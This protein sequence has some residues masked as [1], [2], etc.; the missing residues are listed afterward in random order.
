[1]AAELIAATSAGC[2][3]A[4][5][6]I[7]AGGVVAL[8]TDTFYGLV[9]DPAQP[10]ALRRLARIKDRPSHMP[11]PLLIGKLS[12]LDDLVSSFPVQAQRLAQQWW[13]GALTLLLP[14]APGLPAGMTGGTGVVGLRIAKHPTVALTLV[15]VARP[16]TGT[17]ANR[18]GDPPPRTVT[19]VQAA[20]EGADDG[21]D[22][23]VDGG[24][25]QALAASTVVDCTH[26]PSVVVVRQGAI[27]E[28]YIQQ[29]A[30]AS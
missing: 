15:A 10:R 29:I 25:T 9:V 18:S 21:P 16:V 20:F 3:R 30:H 8:P 4:A 19:A 23:I 1:M 12:Q 6:V 5:E 2:E 22:L 11:F 7:S 27:L 14:A 17:S 24:I 13:P 28:A 26:P